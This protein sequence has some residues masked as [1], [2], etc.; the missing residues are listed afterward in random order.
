MAVKR[1]SPIGQA[2]LLRLIHTH[3]TFICHVYFLY[4]LHIF[5]PHNGVFLHTANCFS[6][7]FL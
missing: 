6:L 4:M 5:F 1:I 2:K 3:Y 7:A